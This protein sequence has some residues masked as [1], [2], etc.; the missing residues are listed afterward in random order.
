MENS[1]VTLALAKYYFA[2]L[3][4]KALDYYVFKLELSTTKKKVDVI[5]RMKFLKNLKKLKVDLEFFEYYRDFVN[6]YVAIVRPLI[7]FKTRDF[8]SNPIKEKSKREHAT[9]IKLRQKFN[10]K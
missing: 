7:K 5:R 1:E 4:I 6:H 10:K 8:V 3:N 2:Y 9:R